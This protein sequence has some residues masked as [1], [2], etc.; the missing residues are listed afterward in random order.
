MIYLDNA[1]TTQPD[2][3][4]IEAMLPYLTVEYGN[5]GS[6]HTMGKIAKR[7][8]D[9]AREQV[10]RLINAE[11]E[12]VIFTS[13]GS[14]ANNMVFSG[15]KDYL[16]KEGKTHIIT[17]EIEHDSVLNSVRRLCNSLGK[18]DVEYIVPEFNSCVSSEAVIDAIN[19]EPK[20]GLVSVMHTNNETGIENDVAAIGKVCQEK[21]I[22]FH[23]DCV[24]ALGCNSLSVEKIR[25]DFMSMSAHKIH[26]VKGVGALY[27]RNP[28]I[29]SPLIA[30]GSMQEFGLRGGTENVAGIVAFGKACEILNGQL[31]QDRIH[32]GRL[33]K[34]FYCV[35]RD[36]LKKYNLEKVLHINGDVPVNKIEKVI[37]IRFDGVDAETLLLMLSTR[38]VY[39]SSGSACRS[40]ESEPSRVLLSL[41]ISE[42]DARSSIR[43]SFSRMNT[44]KE[45][46]EAGQIIADCVNILLKITDS[47]KM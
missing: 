12:Q 45:M 35:V 33:K 29:L 43:V 40:H 24:Q 22:L 27:V 3:E 8:V 9:N 7:A 23:T 6:L 46:S 25:C 37:N 18:F 31:K 39:V 10:S 34:Y 13:G 47:N 44:I 42:E 32:I 36:A 20:T 28:E 11:P 41:G 1:A 15:T 4:V 14:E 17:T 16:L 26:G 30:G 2:P 38:G 19:D 5:A 21:G